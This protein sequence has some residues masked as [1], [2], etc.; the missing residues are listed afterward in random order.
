M[1]NSISITVRD[2]SGELM[3]DS[4]AMALAFGVDESAVCAL[5]LVNGH[6]RIPREWARRGKRRAKE[7]MAHTGSDLILDVLRYW[8]REDHGAELEV[9]YQ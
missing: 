5:P 6:M 4:Q 1:T 2:I 8:A 7:A 3:L 9:V